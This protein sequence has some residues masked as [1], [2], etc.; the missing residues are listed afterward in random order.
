MT[1]TAPSANMRKRIAPG[2]R[3]RI[4]LLGGA[5]AFFFATASM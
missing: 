5:L 4:G 3:G 1:A 2:I